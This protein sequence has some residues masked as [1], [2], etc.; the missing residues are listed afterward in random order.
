MRKAHGIEQKKKNNRV[1]NTQHSLTVKHINDINTL[2]E[3]AKLKA[4]KSG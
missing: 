2:G 1:A 4:N 3:N